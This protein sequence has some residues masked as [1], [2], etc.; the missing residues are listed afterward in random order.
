MFS[1][2]YPKREKKIPTRVDTKTFKYEDEIEL[3]SLKM[4]ILPCVITKMDV[5]IISD[6]VNA[7][8]PLLLS[9]KAMKRAWTSL[10]F[11]DDTAEMF[12]KKIQL[13]CT[14]SGHYHI[15]ILRP[16]PDWVK[17]KYILYLNQMNKKSKTEKF[18]IATKL[19]KQFSQPSAKKL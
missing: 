6:V 2:D 15:P 8:I 14:T 18:K 17:F 5:K 9:K 1:G 16:P 19:H 12:G 11:N 13:L 3:K 4:V 10:N 7:D